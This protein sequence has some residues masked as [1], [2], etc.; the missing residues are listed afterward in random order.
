V[1]ARQLE[2]ARALR[3]IYARLEGS[4]DVQERSCFAAGSSILAFAEG[5]YDDA[6]RWGEAAV[7]SQGLMGTWPQNV[8]QGLVAAI[9]AALVLGRR[10]RVEEFLAMIEGQPAGMRTPLMAAHA[11]RF[12]GRLADSA[13][14]ADVEFAIAEGLLRGVGIPFWLAVARLEHAEGL[15]AHGGDG[16]ARALLDQSRDTFQELR[17]TPW[18]ERVDARS[19]PAASIAEAAS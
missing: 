17:A 5:R 6:L 14:T 10:D 2:Q 15:V 19:V 9:E 16:D 7:A 3:D 18:L 12:R 13:A 8:K 11:H 4:V 1:L